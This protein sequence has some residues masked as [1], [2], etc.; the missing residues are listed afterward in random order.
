MKKI[1]AT[2]GQIVEMLKKGEIFFASVDDILNDF[3]RGKGIK[4]H[5]GDPYFCAQRSEPRGPLVEYGKEDTAWIVEEVAKAE[6]PV[7]PP[8]LPRPK[9]ITQAQ[10]L[11]IQIQFTVA[12]LS[13]NVPAGQKSLAE[14]AKESADYFLEVNGLTV[15]G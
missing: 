7:Q 9:T 12:R 10:Y 6:E 2:R 5:E 15:E 3:P 13:S 8:A 1:T 4:I 14:A 11:D